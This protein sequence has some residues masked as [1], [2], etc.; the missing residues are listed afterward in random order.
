[1]KKVVQPRKV[2]LTEAE[3]KIVSEYYA[4]TMDSVLKPLHSSGADKKILK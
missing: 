1:M 3:K 4:Y 2:R